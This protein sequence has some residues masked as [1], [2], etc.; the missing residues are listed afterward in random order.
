MNNRII[1]DFLDDT[2]RD[3]VLI[4]PRRRIRLHVAAAKPSLS[5][6]RVHQ[7]SVSRTPSSSI[8]TSN[9]AFPIFYEEAIRM[10]QVF[11][12]D[13]RIKRLF[14][15]GFSAGGHFAGLIATEQTRVVFGRHPR[16]SGDYVGGHDAPRRFDSTL[17]RR[18]SDGRRIGCDC[19]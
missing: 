18:R 9:I 15:C 13:P 8:V 17:G 7:G 12:A 19:D 11:R 4:L 1:P 5:L 14:L 16:V 3:M 2:V 10:I 6:K